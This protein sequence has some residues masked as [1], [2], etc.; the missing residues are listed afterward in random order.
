MGMNQQFGFA[1]L[2]FVKLIESNL[3]RLNHFKC[4]MAVSGS[5][6]TDASMSLWDCSPS[7]RNLG[8]F[9]AGKNQHEAILK[10]HRET[11]LCFINSESTTNYTQVGAWQKETCKNASTRSQFGFFLLSS[12]KCLNRLSAF[13]LK[14]RS[15]NSVSDANLLTYKRR[16]HSTGIQAELFYSL[17]LLI[18]SHT[19]NQNEL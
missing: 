6:Q 14:S 10:N 7:M 11:F 18:S 12:F 5:N 19:F 15:L 16:A 1:V 2:A 13:H 3:E 9:L 4:W 8:A 17:N